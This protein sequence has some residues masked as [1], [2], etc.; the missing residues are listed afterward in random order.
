MKICPVCQESNH[1]MAD[2]CMLCGAELPALPSQSTDE[3]HPDDEL[4]LPQEPPEPVGLAL[5]VY[6]DREKRVVAFF[7]FVG[8]VALI[9]REDAAS[10]LFPEIDLGALSARGVSASH[11]S[12]RHARL[13][14]HR[15]Q[16][17][18]EVLPGTTGTQLNRQL[19]DAGQTV[20]ISPG[21][22][23]ILG[24]RVRTKLMDFGGSIDG[25]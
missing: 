21:D 22:R 16:L 5:A 14:R 8:D 15:G 10:G 9:G 17:L 18:L 25:P 2:A 23:I 1:D 13:L 7:E 3:A 4:L 12:R 11:V 19:V 24:G 20:P 6:H